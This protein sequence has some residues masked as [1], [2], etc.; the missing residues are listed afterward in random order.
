VIKNPNDIIENLIGDYLKVFGDGLIGA[1]LYGSAVSHEYSPGRSDINF[2]LFLKDNSISRLRNCVE[3]QKRWSRKGVS[4]PLFLTREYIKS[5]LDT[6]PIEFL[7]MQ[8]CYRLLYGEDIL[9]T[10]EIEKGYLR[11]QCERELKGVMLHLRS[12]F[13]RAENRAGSLRKLLSFSM[14]KLIPL[15]KA[16]L[17]LNDRK[18]P[19]TK[20][21]IISAVEDLYGFGASA[22]SDVFQLSNGNKDLAGLFDRFTALVDT[23]T[24]YI[25]LSITQSNNGNI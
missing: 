12:E 18:I 4:V 1:V 3:T 21:E 15:F 19:S 22:L 20:Y 24:G 25:D 2:A 8:S 23:I 16:I 11:L 6:F 10:I 9:S 14:R 17:V 13:I 5:S 7:D